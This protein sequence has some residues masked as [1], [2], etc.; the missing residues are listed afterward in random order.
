MSDWD[1]DP[2][3]GCG[4]MHPFLIVQSCYWHH[5]WERCGVCSKWDKPDDPELPEHTHHD[6]T[7]EKARMET[8]VRDHVTAAG[9]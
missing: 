8:Y 2:A 9:A 3:M 7:V 6:E 1:A 4:L 5:E